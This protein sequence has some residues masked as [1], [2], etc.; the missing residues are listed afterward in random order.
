MR[1]YSC[2]Q[3]GDFV[4]EVYK[5]SCGGKKEVTMLISN[6]IVLTA[7]FNFQKHYKTINT[8]EEYHFYTLVLPRTPMK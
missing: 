5:L 8:S 7:L 2:L 3:K 1:V 6:Q 4:D